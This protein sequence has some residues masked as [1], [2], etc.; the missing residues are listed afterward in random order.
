MTR[1][2]AADNKRSIAIVMDNLVFSA[3]SVN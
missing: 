1:R 2:N 3:P